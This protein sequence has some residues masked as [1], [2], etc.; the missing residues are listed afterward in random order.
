M[1]FLYHYFDLK[2]KF[3]K[4]NYIIIRDKNQAYTDKVVSP[5]F[6]IAKT[7][8]YQQSKLWIISS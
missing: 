2:I 5:F 6:K 8:S 1:K 3:P 7:Q 4:L